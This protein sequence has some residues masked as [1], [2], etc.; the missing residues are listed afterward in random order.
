MKKN[1][2]NKITSLLLAAVM[3]IGL[4]QPMGNVKAEEDLLTGTE[5]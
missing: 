1:K 5:M 2:R 3:L 4:W